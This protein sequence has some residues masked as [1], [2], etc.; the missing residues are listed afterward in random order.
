MLFQ[1]LQEPQKCFRHIRRYSIAIILASLWPERVNLRVDKSSGI[2]PCPTTVHGDSGS[3]SH[4]TCKRVSVSEVHSDFLAPWKLWAKAIRHEQRML[5]HNLLNETKTKQQRK[6]DINCFM[7]RVLE[8]QEKSGL[9]KE[10][11]VYTGG[12]LVQSYLA[13]S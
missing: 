11:I 9:T 3:R 6:D 1:L 13:K 5:Y 8:N 2:V 12:I 4:T 7:G 10:E